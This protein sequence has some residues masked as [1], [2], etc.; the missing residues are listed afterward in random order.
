MSL[1]KKGT[2]NSKTL[3]SS[4]VYVCNSCGHTEMAKD[5]QNEDRKCPK[6]HSRMNLISSHTESK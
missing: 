4:F 3:I 5:E 1:F 2:C 6:C